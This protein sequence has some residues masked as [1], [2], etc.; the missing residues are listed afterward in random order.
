MGE[1]DR[2]PAGQPAGDGAPHRLRVLV[3]DDEEPIRVALRI[4]LERRGYAVILAGDVSEGLAQA[5][6]HTPDVALVDLRLPGNG[7]TLLRELDGWPQLTGRTVL[8]TGSEDLL[9]DETGK[10]VWPRWLSKPFDFN[11]LV[12]LIEQ[13]AAR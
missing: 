9:L 4:I 12:A 5:R 3:V 13:L 7:L 1:A 8:V 2:E 6:T 11:A 10:P